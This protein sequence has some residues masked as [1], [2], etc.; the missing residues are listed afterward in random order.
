M[1]RLNERISDMTLENGLLN[2]ELAVVENCCGIDV[3][4]ATIIDDTLRLYAQAES[5]LDTLPNGRIIGET[6][7]CDCDC[8]FSLHYELEEVDQIPSAV[9]YNG[10]LI[11]E[12]EHPYQLVE[13]KFEVIGDD[14][15]NR[16]DQYGL[17]QGW[18]TKF[19]SGGDTISNLLF[20]DGEVFK[21]LDIRSLNKGVVS[22][23]VWR[24]SPDSL[25][26][27][28]FDSLGLP[29]E[30]CWMIDRFDFEGPCMPL[31]R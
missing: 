31:E 4:F 13:P 2:I 23:E 27:I 14:T 18:H 29:F 10:K 20:K 17:K 9:L 25:Y 1:Y 3:G 19:R 24:I 21:G 8:C 5:I 22:F 7:L 30:K 16:F 28:S 6:I 26:S 15:I 11:T 12:S